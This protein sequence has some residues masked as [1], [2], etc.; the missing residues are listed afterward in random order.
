MNFKKAIGLVVAV[1]MLNMVGFGEAYALT[2]FVKCEYRT[3]SPI[4]SKASVDATGVTGKYRAQIKSAAGIKTSGGKIANS[5]THEV[6]FDFDSDPTNISQGA[7]AI[8]ANFFGPTN[9]IAYGYLRNYTTGAIVAIK[10]VTCVA[11]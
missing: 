9:N 1:F 8:P 11:K 7:T 10:K 4:R 6:Q 3:K 2:L 5:V